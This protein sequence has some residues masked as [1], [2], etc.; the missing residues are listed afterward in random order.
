MDFRILGPLE[1]DDEN[2][3][4][5][6]LSGRQQRIVLGLLLLHPNEVVSVDQLIDALWPEGAPASAVKTVQILV[7]R[8]R[9]ALE[10]REPARA[11]LQT[12]GTGYVLEVATGE[13]DADRFERLLE[14]GREA[15]A[16]G[17]PQVARTTLEGAL[18]FWRGRPLADFAYEEFAQ[19]EIGRLE[20]LRL[21]ALEERIDADLAL[22]REGLVP[23]LRALVAENPLRER[24]LGQLML[25]LD[26][27][28]RRPEALRAYDEFRRALAEE[29]GLEPSPTLRELQSAMLAEAA[30]QSESEPSTHVPPERR[31]SRR[32][33][34]RTRALF[35]LGGAL[36]LL[37]ALAVAALTLTR[38]SAGIVR[39]E[40][41]TVAG[42]DPDTNRVVA[43]I[44][45]GARPASVAYGEGSLWVAN[46][47]D[48]T[49]SKVDPKEG[50]V[51]RN[52]PTDTDP[53][54]LAAG[55][56]AVW[57]I[58]PDGVVVRIDPVFREATDRIETVDVGALL[59]TFGMSGGLAATRKAVWAV[60]GGDRST[61]RLFRI[62]PA[63]KPAGKRAR[64]VAVTSVSPTAIAFGFGD[65]WVT[66]GF[67]NTVS[68]IEPTGLVDVA[69][70]VGRGANAVAVGEDAVWVVNSLD[71]TVSRIDPGTGGVR[72]TIPVGG[73]P[74]AVAVGGGAVWV[75]NR[76]TEA[77]ARIDPK[78]NR[79]VETIELGR[80][81]GGIVFA[82]G[83]LWVTNQAV[84]RQ[85][86]VRANGSLRVSATDV[87]PT[88]PADWAE[89][90]V[91][92]ATCAK[93]L[94]YPDRPAP[95]GTRLVP[96]VAESLPTRSADGRTY[97]FTI[98]DGFA[99]SP[100]LE[101]PVTAQT[102]KYSIERSLLPKMGPASALVSDIVGQAAYASG[103][104]PHISGVVVEGDKLSIT[105]V[106]PA[107]DFPARI[108]MPFFCA[109]P[110]NTPLDP[111][112]VRAVPS[113]GPY[114]VAEEVPRERIVLRRNPNYRGSRPRRAREIRFTLG[115]APARSLAD[116]LGGRS[117]FMWEVPDRDADAKLTAKYGPASAAARD[118]RQR[119]FIN[120][121]P[122]LG[123]LALNTSRPLFSNVRLRKAVN[124]A[125]DRRAL[126]ERGHLRLG[127]EFPIIPTDQYLP[128]TMPG[129]SHAPL[130]PPGGDIRA[131]R[132]LAPNAHGTAVLYTCTFRFCRQQA[133]V[134]KSNLKALGLEV[135]IREFQFDEL[136]ERAGR[137][138]EPF[139]MLTAIWFADYADPA[140]FLNVLLHQEIRPKGNLNHSYFV[141]KG[142]ARKLDRLADLSGE[143]RY[144]GYRALSVE[145]ARD[146]APW[147]AYATGASRD[148]F[149]GRI[150]CQI[151]HPVYGMDLGALCIR[152]RS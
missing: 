126:A 42:I 64:S 135:D 127:G 113:A 91:N 62:D 97:T 107:P 99:F 57:T 132:R 73:Y 144:N 36:L 28:G 131:A 59:G 146:D 38:P 124:Y 15:L 16:A 67:E 112:G 70:P 118:G 24:L 142:F 95:A 88:D 138:G 43:Q 60:S 2:G 79:V 22:G 20:D 30:A 77:V 71:G 115:V 93:L 53:S 110:L 116:V 48:D 81:P 108:A 40:P 103:K 149:A 25:A 61:P 134:I 86:S 14:Q 94:N 111:D 98:R 87:F 54:A 75:A 4:P 123:Y 3:T 101:E 63:A 96:E 13:L 33:T 31:K 141:D 145:L 66:D 104:A 32:S 10:P 18:G 76:D 74:T 102:F 114:Y 47:E 151:F 109:V 80:T 105:L 29:L 72:M 152:G 19:N 58:G 5:I 65:L 11:I 23:E 7:S 122:S 121:Q 147:V 55:G 139:D 78:T 35:G 92:Y 137:P 6:P 83:K 56:G 9:K 140:D 52:I 34:R 45:V 12:R 8:V 41:N 82:D 143:A 117:D 26:R 89:P 21:A 68:R 150:G 119:Y 84:A 85:R 106:K 44:P 136:F 130:Y 100:P 120:P 148:L 125:I 37:A 128:P 1:A 49:V 50:L 90:L 51:E 46:L 69:I 129:A 27:S 133:R 39:V 17:D